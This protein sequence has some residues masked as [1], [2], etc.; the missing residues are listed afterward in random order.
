MGPLLVS[1]GGDQV[2][3]PGVRLHIDPN[4]DFGAMPEKRPRWRR[5]GKIPRVSELI[6]IEEGRRRVLAA[7][8]PLAVE[9][10]ALEAAL[11]RV[12]A[13]DLRS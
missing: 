9:R 4:P 11:G 2:L 12:L 5:A 3:A 6:S 1:Y 10:V 13:E 8:R 7:V